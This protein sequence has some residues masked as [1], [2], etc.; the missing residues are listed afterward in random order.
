MYKYVFL[1]LYL[2][3]FCHKIIVFYINSN[4]RLEITN[5]FSS[6]YRE[7]VFQV[8]SNVYFTIVLNRPV[9]SLQIRLKIKYNR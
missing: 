6:F 3:L 2:T 5:I 4:L 8:S 9:H 1:I 7:Q